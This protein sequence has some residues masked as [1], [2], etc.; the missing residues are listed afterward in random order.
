M[1]EGTLNSDDLLGVEATAVESDTTLTQIVPE[2][3][4]EAPA[5]RPPMQR[6]ADHVAD[7]FVPVS[8]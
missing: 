4:E 2:M 7:I 3:V 5:S 8:T 6:L 1:I